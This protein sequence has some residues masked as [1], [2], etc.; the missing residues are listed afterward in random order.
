MDAAIRARDDAAARDA[1]A[2]AERE[3]GLRRELDLR[4]AR[5][6]DAERNFESFKGQAA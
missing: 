4:D 3:R 2:A 6:S 1:S 5:I